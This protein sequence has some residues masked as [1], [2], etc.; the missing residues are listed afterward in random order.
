MDVYVVLWVIIQ[1]C[2]TYFVGQIVPALAV[3][4]SFRLVPVTLWQAPTIC[5][6]STLLLSGLL[7][8]SRLILSI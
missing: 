8:C 1:Y 3:K 4:S 7:R 5:F 2:V 6:F